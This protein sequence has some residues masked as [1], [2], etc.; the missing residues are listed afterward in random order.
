MLY[1]VMFL[2][3]LIR[4]FFLVTEESSSRSHRKVCDKQRRIV[5]TGL[6]KDCILRYPA[7]YTLAVTGISQ[8]CIWAMSVTGD[9]SALSWPAER[10]MKTEKAISNAK[11]RQR[12]L[13]SQAAKQAR[14]EVTALYFLP[15][16]LTCFHYASVCGVYVC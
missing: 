4:C 1:F 5:I 9:L 7:C 14:N 8:Q 11:T 3:C 10:K 2:A 16:S 6:I 12:Q 15:K 13:K